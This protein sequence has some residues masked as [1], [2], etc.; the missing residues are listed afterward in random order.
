[1]V[2]YHFLNFAVNCYHLKDWL[3]KDNICTKKEVDKH[4][5]DNVRL[6]NIGAIA[7]ES[8]HFVLT[9]K[10]WKDIQIIKMETSFSFSNPRPVFRIQN[11]QKNTSS[12]ITINTA[13]KALYSWD[14]LFKRKGLQ[15]PF[16]EYH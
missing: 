10:H 15:Q 12:D 8:K 16:R 3:V 1:M 6:R 14:K 9:S 5:N 11:K 13:H 4:I 7:N 2:N